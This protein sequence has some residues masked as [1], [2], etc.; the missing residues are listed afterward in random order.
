VRLADAWTQ[1]TS[2]LSV[3][4][5]ADAA[6]KARLDGLR[7]VLDLVPGPVPVCLELRLPGGAEAVF[8]LP[9]HKVRVTEELVSKLDAI[10]GSGA[11]RCRVA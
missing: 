9:R 5:D 10:F 1:R 11:A 6:D 2:R 8:D 4:V 7:S 3:V